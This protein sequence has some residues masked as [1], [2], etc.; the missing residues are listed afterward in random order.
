MPLQG[1][2]ALPGSHP[3]SSTPPA[4]P[5]NKVASYASLR[6]APESPVGTRR[7]IVTIFPSAVLRARLVALRRDALTQLAEGNG[8]GAGLL[9]LAVR[10]DI[11]L[12]TIDAEAGAIVEP[13]DRAVLLDDDLQIMLAI[14]TDDRKSAA[15]TLPPAAA[16]GLGN[17][18]VAGGVRRL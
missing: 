2:G 13:S 6:H 15:A 1:G 4:N 12:A 3:T 9:S 8:V 16:V 14:Y 7:E 17:E 11:V 5:C 10:I 18:L